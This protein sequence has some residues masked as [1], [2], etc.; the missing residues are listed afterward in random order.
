MKKRKAKP[1]KLKDAQVEAARFG[2]RSLAGF[3]LIALCL[4]GLAARFWF[5]QVTR[6]AEFA[7]RSNSN[8]ISVRSIPP[9]RGLIYDRNG[10]LLAEN[11]AAFRLE[12]VPE[13][14][15]DMTTMLAALGHV[16]ALSDDDIER[17]A[18]LRKSKRAFDSIPLR[19]KLSEDEIARFSTQRW[20]FPGVDV[21]PYLTRAYPR[22]AD[23]AHV[24]GYVGRIDAADATTLDADQYAGTTQIGKTGIERS[25]EDELHGRPGYE[26]VE[27][28]VDKRVI[29]KPISRVAPTP[30]KNLY[31]SID[32]RLQRA[33]QD[34]LAGR[35]GAVVAIDPRNGEVLALASAPSFDPNLFVNG[36]A[37]ADYAA[38]LNNPDKPLLNRA[39]AGGFTPGSTV[40]PYLGL[41]GLELGLRKPQDTVLS[42]GEFFIPGQSRGYRDDVRGGQGLVNLRQAIARSVNTYFY[43]LALDMGIDRFSAWMANFGFGKPTGID[44]PGEA[45]G[46]LPSKAW[47]RGRFNQPFYPGETVIAGI[48]QGYWVITPVQLAN[49]LSTLADGGVRRVPH[50]LHALQ[51]GLNAPRVT[52]PQPKPA[53]NFI[54]NPADWDAVR[55]GMIDVVNDPSG[56]AHG[57]GDGFPYVIAGKTGTAERFSRTGEEWTNIATSAV[58]RH[59]VLF[60]AFTPADAPRVAVVVALKEGRSGAYDAAP[61]ARRILDEWLKDDDG[62]AP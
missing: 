44:L 11:V 62:G 34:A 21:V 38:L 23:F 18:A 30:G 56:T 17:F 50:L 4:S 40:K 57:L 48:G 1:R 53:P 22:G 6:H 7:A 51:D 45:S 19:L 47:K 14:V 46:V 3:L 12:V 26:Q 27:V 39:I 59:E 36:I 43:S 52:V 61:I 16:I 31:L 20:R 25:Y 42:T 33:A 24:I 58:S 41:G 9:T 37:H 29:G 32:A 54:R 5:L 10:V 60:E 2:K 13:Q 49:A 28:N 8:R 35:P 15:Q 55:Q